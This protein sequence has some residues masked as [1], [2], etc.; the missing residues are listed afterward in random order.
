MCLALGWFFF[1]S[2]GFSFVFFVEF[3]VVVELDF[4]FKISMIVVYFYFRFGFIRVFS[5]F[6]SCF[7]NDREVTGLEMGREGGM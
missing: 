6:L 2:L 5:F 3:E 4:I 7:E 1:R